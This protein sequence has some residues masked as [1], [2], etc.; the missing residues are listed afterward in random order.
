MQVIANA[1][2]ASG[3][4]FQLGGDGGGQST[5]FSREVDLSGAATATLTFIYRRSAGANGGTIKVEAS[6]NGGASWTTL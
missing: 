4:F 6:N 2:C 1:Q 3:N 5:S